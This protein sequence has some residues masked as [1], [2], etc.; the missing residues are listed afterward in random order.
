MEKGELETAVDKL[1]EEKMDFIKGKGLNA[2]G[3]LMGIDHEGFQG[4]GQRGR[5]QQAFEGKDIEE[6]G[7]V[8]FII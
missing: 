6:I 2:V 7:I 8:N 3:P 4:Q 5:G 1:I